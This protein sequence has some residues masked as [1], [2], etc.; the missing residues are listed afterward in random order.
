MMGCVNSVEF[1]KP[2]QQWDDTTEVKS[3]TF[4]QYFITGC[5]PLRSKETQRVSLMHFA[6]IFLSIF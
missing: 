2:N 5:G 1:K 3:A 4:T 6:F